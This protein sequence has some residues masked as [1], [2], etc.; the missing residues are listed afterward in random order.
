[1]KIEKIT[2]MKWLNI[3]NVSY[4]NKKGQDSNWTFASRKQNPV[5]GEELKPDA[6]VIVPIH[7]TPEG[8]KLVLIKEFRIP[9]GDYEYGFPAGLIENENNVDSAKR[10]LFEETGLNLTKIIHVSPPCVSSAGLSDESVVYVICECEGTINKDNLEENEDI[11]A[12]SM[13]LKDLKNLYKSGSKLSAKCVPF[14]MTFIM[15]GKIEFN[16]IPWAKI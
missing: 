9:L 8:D 6:V 2:N 15:N 3:F 12:N 13:N 5:L 10:E 1:M 14:L 16:M 4:K 7:K 11:T